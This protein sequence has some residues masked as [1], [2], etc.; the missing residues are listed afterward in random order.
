MRIAYACTTV[1]FGAL[2]GLMMVGLFYTPGLI[3]DP[4]HRIVHLTIVATLLLFAG[5]FAAD[6]LGLMADQQSPPEQQ[7]AIGIGLFVG[8]V[9]GGG[10]RAMRRLRRGRAIE[11]AHEALLQHAATPGTVPTSGSRLSPVHTAGRPE[12]RTVDYAIGVTFCIGFLIGGAALST[13]V[14]PWA[15]EWGVQ[16]AV[17]LFA[18]VHAAGVVYSQVVTGRAIAALNTAVG[19]DWFMSRRSQFFLA[20]GPFLVALPV[21][22][23]APGVAAGLVA[24]LIGLWFGY[25]HTASPPAGTFKTLGQIRAARA[26]AVGTAMPQDR[27]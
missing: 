6:A 10:W 27:V 24:Q 13:V 17:W 15:V 21:S 14:Q 18:M 11:A 25:R 7:R 16:S 20:G 1:L 2:V 5:M 26:A 12:F 9:A 22:M 23:I 4:T 8:Y 19:R 3:R